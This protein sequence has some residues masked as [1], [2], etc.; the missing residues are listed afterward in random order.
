[1]SLT[2]QTPPGMFLFGLTGGVASGKSTVGRLLRNHGVTVIDADVLAR[3][4]VEPG[5]PALREIAETFG[6]HLVVDGQLD[7]AALGQLVFASAEARGRLNAIVHPRVAQLL[8]DELSALVPHSP[9]LA[10]VCYEVPLLFENGLDAWLRPVV[11]VAC[12]EETQIRRAM[13][14][15]GWSREHA[16]ARIAAQMPLADKRARADYVIE[17]AGD[18]TALEANTLD[19]LRRLTALATARGSELP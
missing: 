7:R 1:M 11:L 14:R 6:A 19:V 10:L 15:N 16:M 8:R 2:M 18:L 5:Q 13:D 4:A 3:R 17:N 9:S 12:D